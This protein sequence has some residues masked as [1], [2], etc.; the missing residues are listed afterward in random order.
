MPGS[1]KR[2]QTI[3]QALAPSDDVATLMSPLY[4]LYDLRVA[5]SHLTAASSSSKLATVTARLSLPVDAS[6]SKI[7]AE[8][9]DGLLGAFDGMAKIVE[10]G[11]M[12]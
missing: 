5:C 7:Y 1:L 11:S 2:L 3:L 9:L 8:L 10:T 4:V 12:R 6:L